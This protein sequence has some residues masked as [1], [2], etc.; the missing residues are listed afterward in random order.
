MSD[1]KGM[2]NASK[3]FIVK[4]QKKILNNLNVSQVNSS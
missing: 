3:Q 1:H 2:E 4:S